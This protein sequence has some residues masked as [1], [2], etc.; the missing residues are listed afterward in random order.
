[1]ECLL[2]AKL[3]F[4]FS[5]SD[6]CIFRPSLKAFAIQMLKEKGIRLLLH[7]YDFILANSPF[8]LFFFFYTKLTGE[9]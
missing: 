4:C 1:M 5:Q 7:K 8:F 9:I 2:N 6:I 3:L